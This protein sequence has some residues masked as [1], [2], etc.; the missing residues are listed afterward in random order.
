M[1]VRE[2]YAPRAALPACLKERGPVG[3]IGQHEAAVITAPPRIQPE[4]KA[5]ECS[6]KRRIQE[7]PAALG[8]ARMSAPR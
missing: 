4:Q 1:T 7:E 6:P 5:L 2:Q 3:M 8:G